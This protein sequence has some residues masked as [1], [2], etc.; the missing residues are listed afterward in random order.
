[1]SDVGVLW[2]RATL[3]R[4]RGENPPAESS[5]VYDAELEARVREYQRE[6]MLNVDGIVGART[7]IAMIAELDVPGTPLL[8]AGH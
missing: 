5:E 8:A 6:R 1:M 4:I 7:Q 2:L 3:A